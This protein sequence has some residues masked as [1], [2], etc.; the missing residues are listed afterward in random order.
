M[1]RLPHD[2]PIPGPILQYLEIVAA[3]VDA[4]VHGCTPY[5]KGL[6]LLS[7]KPDDGYYAY[8][9]RM[10]RFH[11]GEDMRMPI[12]C[13]FDLSDAIAADFGVRIGFFT[14]DHSRR[15]ALTTLDDLADRVLKRIGLSTTTTALHWAGTLH[16]MGLVDL[17]QSEI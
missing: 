4:A 12:Q 13:I 14:L 1:T 7:N 8:V 2:K 16:E 9:W 11:C 3:D 5:G 10:A 6:K 17:P 15:K